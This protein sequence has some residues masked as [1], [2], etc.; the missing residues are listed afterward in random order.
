M[1]VLIPM[2]TY[3]TSFSVWV[4]T[5][6]VALGAFVLLFIVFANGPDVELQFQKTIPSKLEASWIIRNMDAVTRWPQWFHSVDKVTLLNSDHLQTG[7]QLLIQIDP[8]KGKRKRFSLKAEVLDYQ[9][10]HLLRMKILE[11][12]S[13]RLTRL[14]DNLEWKIEIKPAQQAGTLATQA[15]RPS[16]QAP[17]E[18]ILV[19]TSSGKT[20]HWRSRL[21]GHLSEK[22]LMHQVFYPNLIKL[23]ELRQPFSADPLPVPNAF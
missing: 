10:G 14:F 12:S 3:G 20:R 6:S 7:A 8:K 21:F 5:L 15:Q 9:P 11:D 19:G 18:T 4:K 22:I 2:K 1:I 23:S 16:R 17:P 13:L